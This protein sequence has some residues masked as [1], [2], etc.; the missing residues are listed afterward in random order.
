[1]IDAAVETLN[2]MRSE[3]SVV[4]RIRLWLAIQ[5]ALFAAWLQPF[6]LSELKERAVASVMESQT[7]AMGDT[8]DE[9]FGPPG[10]PDLDD[11]GLPPNH[12]AR[13]D[14]A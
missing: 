10:S 13:D 9:I 12:P 8:L 11:D 6:D 14:E 5:I 4:G 1:M 3:L 7:E 2:D